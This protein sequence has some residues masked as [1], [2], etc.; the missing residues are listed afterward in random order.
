MTFMSD[1]ILDIEKRTKTQQGKQ[2][3]K[4]YLK[5]EYKYTN[6][7]IAVCLTTNDFYNVNTNQTIYEEL[8]ISNFQC[9]LMLYVQ[10]IPPFCIV[11]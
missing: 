4:L 1:H 5:Y 7:Y 10:N 8:L 3:H 6:F 2:Y 11:I 9:K